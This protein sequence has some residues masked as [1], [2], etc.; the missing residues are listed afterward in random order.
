RNRA[1]AAA[2]GVTIGSMLSNDASTNYNYQLGRKFDTDQVDAYFDRTKTTSPRLI[3]QSITADYEAS[4][5]IVGLFGM[6]ET[7]IGETDVIAGLRVERTDFDASAPTYNETTGAIGVANAGREYTAWFPNL[8]VRRA[9]TPDLIGRFTLSRGINRPNFPQAVPGVV[10]NTETETVRVTA[11]N[12]DLKPAMS[13]NIDAGLE[14]YLRPLGV[15]AVHAFYK[16]LEDYRYEATR[17]ATYLGRQALLTRP[18]NAPEGKLYGLEFDWQ[19]QFTFLP[20]FFSDFGV[21]ANYTLTESEVILATP[22]AGRTKMDLQGQSKHTYNASLFYERGPVNLRLSYTK[23]SDS[24]SEVNADDADLDIYWK[25]RGQLDLTGSYQI[26]SNISAFFEAKNLTN[27]AG[28]R[29]Y[30]ER[31]RVLEYEKFGYSLFGGVRL[32][33]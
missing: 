24:L 17:S 2:P 4:E 26:N 9:F 30:G 5:K 28:V 8:T 13:N 23:R 18:E 3:P 14:Y 25:G 20:G 32:K 29:Y 33:L 11:G 19:Q 16:D 31:Q 1:A 7:R 12:P 15:I 21:F 27:S 10:E 22:Y 6:A